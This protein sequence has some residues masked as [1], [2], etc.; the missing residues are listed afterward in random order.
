M[1]RET[2]KLLKL[3]SVDADTYR[4]RNGA[5]I[6]LEFERSGFVLLHNATEEQ[7]HEWLAKVGTY[8]WVRGSW[9]RLPDFCDMRV[10][11]LETV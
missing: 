8:H 7:Y 6:K 4:S 2:P 1:A 5:Y 3:V 9:R 10:Y 11:R